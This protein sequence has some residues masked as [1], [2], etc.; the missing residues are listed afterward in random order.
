MALTSEQVYQL[1]N[2]VT[3][4]NTLVPLGTAIQSAETAP[5]L[6]NGTLFVGNG[7]GVGTAVTPSGD[8]TMTNAGVTAI[9]A[10][11][12]LTGM[13]A[14]NLL[15]VAVKTIT[16]AQI[17]ALNTTPIELVAAPGSGL[18]LIPVAL[19]ATMTYATATYSANAAG[20]SVR[21]TNGSGQTC[22]M[23]L[24]QAFIQQTASALF[25]I[26]AGATG[27]VPVANAALVL[28]ADT[29]N[30]TTGD[31]ALKIQVWHRVVANPAF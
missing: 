16:T 17:L 27:I 20:F 10:N 28:Y 8:V 22:A 30:P 4:P 18:V 29:A 26:V 5:P 3:H 19:Y 7:S 12:V 13:L 15:Q 25:H 11:K 9:G 23:T 31:S 24:T 6:A 1:N 14:K 21:Y 2:L